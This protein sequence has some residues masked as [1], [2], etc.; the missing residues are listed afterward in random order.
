MS[1]A[2]EVAT[3]IPLGTFPAGLNVP[4]PYEGSNPLEYVEFVGGSLGHWVSAKRI[5]EQDIFNESV[6][7][8]LIP[9]AHRVPISNPS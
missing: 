5:D 4:V 7:N 3:T 9:R 8:Q 1:A 6:G 2:S